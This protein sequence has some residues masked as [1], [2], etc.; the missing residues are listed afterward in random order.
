MA[1]SP[2]SAFVLILVSVVSQCLI[3]RPLQAATNS[4]CQF[5]QE[6]IA[7]KENLRRAYLKGNAQAAKDYQLLLRKHAELLAQCRTANWPGQQA[8]WLRLYPCD[9]QPGALDEVLD[10]IV[11]LGYNQVYLE[12]FYDSLVL[13]PK[14]SN[15]TPWISVVELPGYEN[16]DLLAETI[17]KGHERGLKVYAWLFSLNFGY[18]YSQDPERQKVLA[19]NGKG[20]NSLNFV[21]DL[22]Q[23]FIDPYH[24]IAR[25][26]YSKLLQ[27]V[28]QR[29]PDG[30]LFDYIRYPRGSGS[31][32]LVS[33]VKDLWIYGEASQQVLLSRA[34]NQQ[35]RWLLERY[36]NQGS[37]TA[38]DLARVRQLYPEEQTPLWQGR[39][40]QANN[41]LST[42]QLDL[43]YFTVA[44]AAQGIIDFLNFA[45]AQ[46]QSRGIP[47]GA[48]FFPD[49]NQVV[50]QVGFDSRLQPWDHFSSS[51]E[52]HPMSYATCGHSNCIV[53]QVKQ[54][55]NSSARQNQV[56]PVLAGLW[57][58]NYKDRPPLEEQMRAIRNSVPQINHISHFAYSWIEPELDRQRRSCN[59]R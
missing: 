50:G 56:M 4:Y 37:I 53:E 42:L 58:Q 39:D 13:L 1:K 14:N 23:A 2:W 29:R 8:I 40:P 9:V 59:W 15:Y 48:V 24:Q 22:S 26:D 49:G 17:K 35:G 6:A 38:N 33:K 46:V 11:N 21:H 3:T 52:W 43:W 27:A 34:Q 57:G 10:R 45:A 54:V 7:A 30:V 41:N 20:E 51:L 55:L 25:Q 19:R 44:H 32:S 36:V 5:N 47:A 16:R 28:L 12:V 18:L 31:Q